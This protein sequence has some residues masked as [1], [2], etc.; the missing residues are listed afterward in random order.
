M[1][2]QSGSRDLDAFLRAEHPGLVRFVDLLVGDLPVAEELAQEA[3]VRAADRWSRVGRLER[4]DAWLRHV[5]R[6][7]A[8][9]HLRRRGAERRALQRHGGDEVASRLVDVP[10]RDEVHDALMALSRDDREV[11]VLR[12][13]VGLSV[14][15]AAAELGV[16][17]TA[18]TSRASRAA[19]RLRDLLA[20]EAA[21]VR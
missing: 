10:T 19:A 18:L 12:H 6:N 11:L 2:E 13:H 17:T 14:E 1:S 16:T 3:L 9:S 21:D 4:P 5:A 7:L 8:R 20:E 15:E